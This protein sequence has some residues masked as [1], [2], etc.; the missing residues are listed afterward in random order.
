[1]HGTLLQLPLYFSRS[2]KWA[3]LNQSRVFGKDLVIGLLEMKSYALRFPFL[4]RALSR[5]LQER[6]SLSL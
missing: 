5:G 1:M 4:A 2:S 6:E 3:T